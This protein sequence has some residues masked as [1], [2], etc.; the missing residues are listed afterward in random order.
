MR[1][2]ARRSAAEKSERAPAETDDDDKDNAMLPAVET[3][4]SDVTLTTSESETDV[5]EGAGWRCGIDCTDCTDESD[6]NPSR[7]S[8][9]INEV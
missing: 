5:L 9:S 1:A 7:A 3:S 8:S 6:A 4:Q 2:L